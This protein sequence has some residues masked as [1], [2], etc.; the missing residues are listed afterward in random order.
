MAE[1]MRTT[2]LAT[3]DFKLHSLHGTGNTILSLDAPA[4]ENTECVEG[5]SGSGEQKAEDSASSVKRMHEDTIPSMSHDVRADSAGLTLNWLQARPYGLPTE[6][7]LVC[8][9]MWRP[10]YRTL[11]VRC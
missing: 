5:G 11:L 1:S 6:R 2:F 9:A 8:E 7:D 10:I 4:G 3:G